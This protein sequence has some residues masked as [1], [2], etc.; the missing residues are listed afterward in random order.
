VKAVVD[1]RG[2][3]EFDASKPDCTPRKL[4]D[5]GRLNAMGWNAQTDMREGLACAYQDY[6]N[7]AREFD[8]KKDRRK[9]MPSA[10]PDSHLAFRN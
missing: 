4:M 10:F 8:S 3:I 7:I 6:L 1:Y 5:V 2:A 9:G